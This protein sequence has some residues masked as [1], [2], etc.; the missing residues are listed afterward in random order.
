MLRA[1]SPV[2]AVRA[3]AWLGTGVCGW[4][5]AMTVN[6]HMPDS[7]ITKRMVPRDRNLR[8]REVTVIIRVIID[9]GG[10]LGLVGW[11]QRVG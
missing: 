6:T 7:N 4:G 3:D 9:S 11:G 5:V 8:R 1:D 2:A 10:F